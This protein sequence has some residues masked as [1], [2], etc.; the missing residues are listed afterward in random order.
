MPLYILEQMNQRNQ[1]VL[2]Q[3]KEK[4]KSGEVLGAD[5]FI[6]TMFLKYGSHRIPT[7]VNEITELQ[8][9]LTS[10]GFYTGPIDGK[11]KVLTEDAV[12][13]YQKANPPLVIDGTVGRWTREAL[14]K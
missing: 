8:K 2:D 14:N 12:K 6:F 13:A 11:F 9:R 7:K 10:E 3:N 1:V 5:K 4:E